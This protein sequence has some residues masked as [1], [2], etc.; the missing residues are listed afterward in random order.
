MLQVALAAVVLALGLLALIA[1][2]LPGGP[3]ADPPEATASDQTEAPAVR[4]VTKPDAPTPADRPA[5][6]ERIASTPTEGPDEER[7]P[8]R[9]PPESP[10][11]EGLFALADASGE[12]VVR[13]P[14][15][16][17]PDGFEPAPDDVVVDGVLTRMVRANTGDGPELTMF[18]DDP[19]FMLTTTGAFPGRIGTCSITPAA[20]GFTLEM[21]PD[22]AAGVGA[23]VDDA[24][25]AA[26]DDADD[27]MHPA[28]VALDDPELSDAAKAWLQA[29]L[30]DAVEQGE[31]VLENPTNSEDVLD[32]ING[33]VVEPGTD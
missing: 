31:A 20:E 5:E 19:P 10:E 1:L 33:V 2:L 9:P 24:R 4:R 6:D 25:L 22:V 18:T 3:E 13:C 12:S 14:I 21:S 7:A 15:D 16:A 27:E 8:E 30:D 29:R 23:D 32:A 17:F 28:Q 26:M 11:E